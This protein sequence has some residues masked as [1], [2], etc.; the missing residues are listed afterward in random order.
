M[1]NVP[2]DDI[3]RIA[4]VIK[5]AYVSFIRSRGGGW[6]NY[7]PS[8][9]QNVFWTKAAE[10]C[11]QHGLEPEQHVL[12]LVSSVRECLPYMLTGTNAVDRTKRFIGT[13][14]NEFDL[15]YLKAQINYLKPYLTNKETLTK[16]LA[17][18]VNLSP[19]FACI[20]AIRF[21]ALDALKS[22]LTDAVIEMYLKPEYAKLLRNAFKVEFTEVCNEAVNA[23]KVNA[24]HASST[25]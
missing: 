8:S 14:D 9:K 18:S 4:T 17:T 25:R 10:L 19:L 23:A 12:A 15:R 16:V 6:S 20:S 13:Y 22:R 3:D 21:G 24:I 2:R 7:N 11:L 1:L 5:N